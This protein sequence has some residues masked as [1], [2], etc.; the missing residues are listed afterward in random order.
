MDDALT[1]IMAASVNDPAEESTLAL[2][3]TLKEHVE[4]EPVGQRTRRRREPR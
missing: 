2:V 3:E 1:F 4:A